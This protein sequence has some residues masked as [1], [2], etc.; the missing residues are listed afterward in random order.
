[1]RRERKLLA[2]GPGP[3]SSPPPPPPP[4]PPPPP[5]PPGK[6]PSQPPV[7]R[8]RVLKKGSPLAGARSRSTSPTYS[9]DGG[10]RAGSLSTNYFDSA[11][12]SWSA[13]GKSPSR[14]QA[15]ESLYDDDAS[16]FLLEDSDG[17]HSF[18]RSPEDEVHPKGV[19]SYKEK[20]A[21]VVGLYKLN[22]VAPQL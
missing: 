5:P 1:M 10:A 3:A 20:A 9:S 11:G 6:V 12:R 13:R 21:L 2:G 4:Q 8:K 22:S 17:R 16:D 14:E 19:F 15:L 18:A 7:V